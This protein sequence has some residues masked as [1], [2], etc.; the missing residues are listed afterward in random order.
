MPFAA[1][2]VPQTACHASPPAITCISLSNDKKPRHL[3]EAFCCIELD[4]NHLTDLDMEYCFVLHD[5]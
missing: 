4:I 5:G 3:D 2:Y 1:L